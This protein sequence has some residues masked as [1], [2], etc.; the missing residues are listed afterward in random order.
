VDPDLL[1]KSATGVRVVD[2]SVTPFVPSGHTQAPTYAIAERGSDLEVFR[3][4]K[5]YF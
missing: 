5:I 1:L 3:V 4:L 2:A